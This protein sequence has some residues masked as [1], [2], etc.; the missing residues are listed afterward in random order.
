MAE[1]FIALISNI[2]SAQGLRP[3]GGFKWEDVTI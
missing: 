1:R 2:E 3:E